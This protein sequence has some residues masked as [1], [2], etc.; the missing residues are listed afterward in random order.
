MNAI[1][2]IMVVIKLADEHAVA[3]RTKAAA[4]GLCLEEWL[5]RLAASERENTETQGTASIVDE[6]SALRA[7]IKPDPEG[8]TA[9]DYVLHGRQ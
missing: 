6:M 1:G 9:H 2:V 4:E 5:V 3:L 8:W 7:R